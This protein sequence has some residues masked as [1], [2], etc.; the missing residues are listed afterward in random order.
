MS[1]IQQ[2]L[3]EFASR[4][5]VVPGRVFE[6]YLWTNPE[7]CSE[8]F[9]RVRTEHELTVDD[10]GTTVTELNRSGSGIQGYDNVNGGGVYLPRTFCEECGG[11][12]RADPAPDSKVQATRRA[13]CI[14]DRLEEQDIAVDRPALRR[15]VRTLKSKPDLVG[16]DREI[17]ERATKIAVGRAQR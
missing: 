6:R 2:S 9:A 16:L 3:D 8:C 17:Y 4:R 13:S 11:R 12:G 7:V 5:D 10:W 1:T 15:A 14:G